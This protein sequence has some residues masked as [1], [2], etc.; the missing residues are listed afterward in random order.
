MVTGVQD[1]VGESVT[2][3]V[4]V[5]DPVGVSVAVT[6]MVTGV[7]VSVKVGVIVKVSEGV[8]VPVGVWLEGVKVIV[9]VAV[10]RMV[11]GGDAGAVGGESLF[12]HETDE[13]D[14]NMART[15]KMTNRFKSVSEKA[16]L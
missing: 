7:N 16:S 14:P 8:P 2:V 13:I 6:R 1:E 10:T 12:L 9:S 4:G 3:K 15:K 11:T 5:C